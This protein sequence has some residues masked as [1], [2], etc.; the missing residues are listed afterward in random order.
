MKKRIFKNIKSIT[1]ILLLVSTMLPILASCGLFTRTEIIDGIENI[2]EGSMS[3]SV[4][5]DD[6]GATCAYPYVVWTAEE[7]AEDYLVQLA[8]DAAFENIIES[9]V[10]TGTRYTCST[11]LKHE[12]KYYIR[13]IARKNVDGQTVGISIA[14]SSFTTTKEHNT[15]APDYTQTRMLFDFED[16]TTESFNQLFSMNAGGDKTTAEIVEGAGVNGS[17]ALKLS[18]VKGDMG[19]GAMVCNLLPT[20]KKVWTGS[21]AIRF[22]IRVEEGSS[23]PFSFRVGKR[24]YQTWAKSFT[25]KNHNG[26]YVTIPYEVMEDKGGGDGIWDLSIMTFMQ[27]TFTGSGTVYIDEISIGSDENYQ[28]DSTADAAIG[29]VPGVLENFEGD[30][31]ADA[32]ANGISLYN[33]DSAFTQLV[34]T[35]DGGHEL[36][37]KAMSDSSFVSFNKQYYEINK[38]DFTQ[39]DGITFKISLSHQKSGAQIMIKFGSYLNVYTETI[40]FS[41]VKAGEYVT[42]KIPISALTLAEGSSGA[43]NYDKID[44]LQIFVKGSQYCYVTLDDVGFYKN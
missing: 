8:S 26:V 2:P 40:D 1:A 11:V 33:V 7:D 30:K 28:K 44:T 6:E 17:K 34:D 24:G 23:V 43:L 20:D 19:W 25:V 32:V 15:D 31:A 35:D 3:I 42:V 18:C 21:T 38:Y 12:T 37:F 41:D 4:L 39:V 29:I 36:R 14:K 13:V 22:H 16:Y 9:K 5:T 10:V 27:F